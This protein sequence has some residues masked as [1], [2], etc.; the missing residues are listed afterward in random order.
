MLQFDSA[1]G[2]EDPFDGR[3]EGFDTLYGERRFDF[4][5]QGIWGLFA[6]GNLRTPG[7]RMTFAPQPRWQ[8]MLS[9]RKFE[10][11]SATDAWSGVGLRDL[12]G[13]AGRSLGRQLEGSFTWTAIRDRLTVETGVAHLWAGRF[14]RETA[15]PFHGDPAYFYLVLTTTF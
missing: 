12:T 8:A 13:Q 9:Y 3:N 1:S 6:R 11:D 14:L 15:Q 7:V 2:D 10:L 4:A 5:P